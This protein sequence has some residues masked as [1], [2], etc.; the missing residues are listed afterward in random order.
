M[1]IHKP[2]RM[3]YLSL[4]LHTVARG[5]GVI[6]IPVRLVAML[7]YKYMLRSHYYNTKHPEVLAPGVKGDYPAAHRR[8]PTT[9]LMVL[10]I[11]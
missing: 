10:T 11:A 6:F 1:F 9:I 4:M 8:M 3:Q 7:V 5:D 2:H